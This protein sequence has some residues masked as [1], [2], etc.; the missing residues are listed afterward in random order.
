MIQGTGGGG[1]LVVH[2]LF[3]A[4]R[5]KRSFLIGLF[6]TVALLLLGI[7]VRRKGSAALSCWL[8]P[9]T[10]IQPVAFQLDIA[11]AL[12]VGLISVLF[13][14][15]F[16]VDLVYNYR[17]ANRGVAQGGMFDEK[18]TAA[19]HRQGLVRGLSGHHFL[20][21]LCGDQHRDQLYRKRRW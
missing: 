4:R 1:R 15:T 8:I 13:S 2:L 14:F 3:T 11:G 10:A 5:V 20:S 12:K 19:L 21:P 7:D 9:L 18:A 6:T 17:H 16:F